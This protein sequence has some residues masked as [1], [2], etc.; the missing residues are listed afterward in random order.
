[1]LKVLKNL[2]KSI[3]SVV[4]IVI[5]LCIQATVDLMLPDYTSKIVNVGIQAGGIEIPI[6]K[7]MSKY[8]YDFIVYRQR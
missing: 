5:L 8:G 2:R 6:P 7:F 3:I 4:A 1:M